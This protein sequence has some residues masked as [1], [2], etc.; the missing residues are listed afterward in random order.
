MMMTA[1][2]PLIA[3]ALLLLGLPLLVGIFLWAKSVHGDVFAARY[4][5]NRHGVRY[6]HWRFRTAPPARAL[7][8]LNDGD[9]RFAIYAI[10]PTTILGLLL[11][12]TRIEELPG[13]WN[14]LVGDIDIAE[15]Q[16][17]FADPSA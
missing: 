8:P 3:S 13:L 2:S 6:R 7:A 4:R 17:I 5:E 10:S 16:T 12:R 14:V 15:F 1:R 9:G 11:H